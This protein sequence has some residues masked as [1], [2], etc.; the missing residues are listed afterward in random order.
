MTGVSAVT[1][2]AVFLVLSGTELTEKVE[3]DIVDSVVGVPEYVVVSVTGLSPETVN[4][5]SLLIWPIA[6][7]ESVDPGV[8]V[9]L[10]TEI[11]GKIVL[12][13]TGL[14]LVTVDAVS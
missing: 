12:S 4:A 7:T 8:V 13:V 11:V 9:C 14:L 3:P 1:V 10:V 5:V 6:N 2:D